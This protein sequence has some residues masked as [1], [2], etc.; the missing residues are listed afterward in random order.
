MAGAF[1]A[2]RRDIPFTRIQVAVVGQNVVV[3]GVTSGLAVTV[4]VRATGTVSAVD[5]K[6]RARIESISLGDMPLP[7][8][9]RDQVLREANAS[10]DFS[11]YDLP[12]TVD[13]VE[14]HAGSLAIR[15]SLR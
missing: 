14:L 1:L 2:N 12:L 6:P 7:A 10:L 8:F 5:G 4:P 9:A 3:D 15:G 11:R 13:A